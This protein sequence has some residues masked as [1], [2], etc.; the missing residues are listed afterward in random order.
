[1]RLA[2]D[3]DKYDILEFVIDQDGRWSPD[4][5]R[6]EPGRN[7]DIDLVFP[8]LH[9]TFGEDGTVQGLLELAELPY[10]GAGVLASA[11]AMDKA[12]TKRICREA[13]LPV[14]PYIIFKRGLFDPASIAL[15]FGF[16][17]FVKPANLGSSVGISK[18]K[19]SAELTQA[20]EKAATYDRKILVEEAI[21]GREFECAVLGGKFP[22]ASAPCE[23][24]L[25]TP[26]K[27]NIF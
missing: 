24:L 11:V 20:L 27:T 18:A 25:S 12:M 7:P 14:G 9:G 4:S 10:V 19:T 26:S 8:L 5:I 2:L 1:M 15:P 6:P 22:R 23:I 13:G 3:A 21:Q 17:V 16:P